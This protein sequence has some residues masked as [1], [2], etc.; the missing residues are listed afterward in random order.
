MMRDGNTKPCKKCN[1]VLTY[2]YSGK[3]GHDYDIF[4]YAHAGFAQKYKEVKGSPGKPKRYELVRQYPTF[5]ESELGD[6]MSFL[7]IKFKILCYSLYN[8]SHYKLVIVETTRRLVY[9]GLKSPERLLAWKGPDPD[10]AI[11]TVWLTPL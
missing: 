11:C 6:T 10:F 2:T 1:G 3:K 7:G 9:N 4:A 5:P 8:G